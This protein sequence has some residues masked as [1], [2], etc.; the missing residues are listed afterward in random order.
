MKEKPVYR[1]RDLIIDKYGKSKYRL[2]CDTVARWLNIYSGKTYTADSI[3]S[4]SHLQS[5]DK[6][7][8]SIDEKEALRKLFG[9]RTTDAL[10]TS[11][12][13]FIDIPAA[14]KQKPVHECTPNFCI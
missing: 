8:L 3:Y 11:S 9:L 5:E 14:E 12:T 1:L 2:G 4:L 13:N 6:F 7:M 10:Y